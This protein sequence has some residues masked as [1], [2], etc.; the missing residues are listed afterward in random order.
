[1]LFLITLLFASS[2]PVEVVEEVDEHGPC[3]DVDVLEGHHER[4]DKDQ[5]Q[6]HALEVRV[7]DQP[8]RTCLFI[9]TAIWK[10]ELRIEKHKRFVHKERPPVTFSGVFEDKGQKT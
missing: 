8:G 1:M 9:R 5:D 2:H 6:H 7:L 4:A 3:L 10:M